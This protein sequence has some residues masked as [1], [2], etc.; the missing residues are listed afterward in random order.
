MYEVYAEFELTGSSWPGELS[1][2]E[3]SERGCQTR[4]APFVGIESEDSE[5]WWYIFFPVEDS[6][7]ELDDRTV[8][9]FLGPEGERTTGSARGTR[10]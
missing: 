10:R 4:F 9:C 1:V 5:W 3:R 8:T 7:N 6:W 2:S